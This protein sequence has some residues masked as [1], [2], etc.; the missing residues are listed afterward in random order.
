MGMMAMRWAAISRRASRPPSH[1]LG[2]MLANNRKETD[3]FAWA[4]ETGQRDTNL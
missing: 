1:R 3:E 2:A 4:S